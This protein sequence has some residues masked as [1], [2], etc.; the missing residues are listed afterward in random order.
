MV[1]QVDLI[2]RLMWPSRIGFSLR[3]GDR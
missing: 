1:Y 3:Y 2:H